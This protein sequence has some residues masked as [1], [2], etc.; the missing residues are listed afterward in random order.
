[1][2]LSIEISNE[3][4]QFLKAAAAIQGKS[5]KEYV[6]D[7]A[8]PT[9]EEQEAFKRLESLLSKRKQN[10]L[11]GHISDKTIDDIFDE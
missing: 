7:S 10:A 9:D 6:L 8:L 11:E 1:M 5:I 3:Q 2:R 4:H